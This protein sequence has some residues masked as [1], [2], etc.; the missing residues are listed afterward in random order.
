MSLPTTLYGAVEGGGTKFVCA[1]GSG[2]DDILARERFD[3]RGP[4]E[5]L[6]AVAGFLARAAG[7]TRLA[8][9]GLAYFGPLELDR[10]RAAYGHMLSTP[11]PG[12]SGAPLVARLAER[13]GAPVE[14]D[15]DA[16]AAALAEWRWG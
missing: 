11:N 5:T 12:W 3:T 6:S 10:S 9:I 2:P 8:S 1:V 13:L 4:I 7:G 14:I 16:N 15:T